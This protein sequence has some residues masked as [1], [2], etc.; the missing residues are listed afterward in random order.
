MSTWIIDKTEN[1]PKMVNKNVYGVVEGFNSNR[2]QARI[3]WNHKSCIY[4]GRTRIELEKCDSCVWWYK[5]ED[6]NNINL[7][8]GNNQWSEKP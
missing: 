5:G 7:C 8:R 3:K 4:H 1:P 2:S 6:C